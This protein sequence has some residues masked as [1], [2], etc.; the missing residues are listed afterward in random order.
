MLCKYPKC[1]ILGLINF[2]VEESEKPLTTKRVLLANEDDFTERFR[3]FRPCHV[4]LSY[5][6]IALELMLWLDADY[7]TPAVSREHS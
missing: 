1:R 6:E 4:A 3:T 5:D 2:I 7:A